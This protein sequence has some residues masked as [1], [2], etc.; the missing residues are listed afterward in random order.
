MF[1]TGKISYVLLWMTLPQPVRSRHTAG[2]FCIG[3]NSFLK[4]RFTVCSLC[5][6]SFSVSANISGE[7][8]SLVSTEDSMCNFGGPMVSY[9]QYRSKKKKKQQKS[10]VR[11]GRWPKIKLLSSFLLWPFFSSSLSVSVSLC[12]S[13]CLSVS[14]SLSNVKGLIHVGF[15]HSSGKMFSLNQEKRKSKPEGK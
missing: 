13:V 11:L 3:T 6:L 14:L 8:S 9:L 1:S 7:W 5:Q 12:V 2:Q 10:S 4:V 15:L